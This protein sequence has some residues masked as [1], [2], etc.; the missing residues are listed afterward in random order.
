MMGACHRLL[1]LTRLRAG[2]AKLSEWIEADF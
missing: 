1:Q 2:A